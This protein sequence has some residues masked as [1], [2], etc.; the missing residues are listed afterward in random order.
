MLFFL[1]I[2]LSLFC[3]KKPFHGNALSQKFL[4]VRC[5]L[6]YQ[7]L[8][9]KKARIRHEEATCLPK[10]LT[11]SHYYGNP[12][13]ESNFQEDDCEIVFGLGEKERKEEE[14]DFLGKQLHKI[15]DRINRDE[16]Q[17]VAEENEDK[18][19]VPDAESGRPNVSLE[20]LLDSQVSEVMT[21]KR[22]KTTKKSN[23][24]NRNLT[25]DGLSRAKTRN[26]MNMT[27]SQRVA[28]ILGSL[29]PLSKDVKRRKVSSNQSSLAAPRSKP[30]TKSASQS[31][32]KRKREITSSD[33]EAQSFP[34][35]KKS[36]HMRENMKKKN[37]ERTVWYKQL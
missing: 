22:K 36:R 14:M 1:F 4:D 12:L 10:Q 37:A 9:N 33:S 29:P 31:N 20:D 6:C 19:R 32:L 2:S 7:L 13:R 18:E 35:L 21:K 5:C 26:M 30:P 11:Q 16:V 34:P 23:K 3:Q 8:D 28:A 17:H 15:L 24:N 25:E 27:M